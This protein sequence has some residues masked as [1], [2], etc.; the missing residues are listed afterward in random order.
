M[1]EQMDQIVTELGDF[2]RLRK[3]RMALAESC[4]GGLAASTLTD[5]PGSS[6]WFEGGIVSYDNRVKERLLAIPRAV[7]NVDGA[8]SQACV[9]AMVRGVCRVFDVP[10]GVAI[11]GIA[12]PGGGSADKPVGLVWMSW[13][14]PCHNW[15]RVYRFHGSRREIKSQS[16]GAAIEELLVGLKKRHL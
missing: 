11:S 1:H 12:G 6:E 10:V 7:L 4:T 16:V 15:S 3:M 5:I 8:V 2:L 9:D 13:Q 14:L